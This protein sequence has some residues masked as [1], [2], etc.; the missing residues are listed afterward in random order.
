MKWFL[1]RNE[2]Y[3]KISFIFPGTFIF[4]IVNFIDFLGCYI[5]FLVDSISWTDLVLSIE[6]GDL[7]RIGLAAP[8]DMAGLAAPIDMAGLAAPID[9]A[10]LAAPIG[11]IDPIDMTVHEYVRDNGHDH[12]HETILDLTFLKF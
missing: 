11:K 12:V 9:M 3:D 2:C 8:I 5:D 6:E 4:S 7:N 1:E 10:G